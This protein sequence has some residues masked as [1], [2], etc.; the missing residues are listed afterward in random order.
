MNFLKKISPKIK[1]DRFL[2]NR[3]SKTFI[4]AELSGNHEGKIKNVFKAID[5]IKK[6]GA[7]AIK[8]QSYEPQTIT[9]NK[10]NKYFFINDKSIWKGKYL[11]DLYKQ[12][13]TP[14]S[15]HKKIFKYAKKKKLICF[16]SPFDKS[17]VDLLES[18][19]CPFYKIASPEITDLKLID[20]VSKKKKPIIISTGIADE[21]DINLA[22]NQCLKNNNKNII[23]LSCIS[24]YPTDDTEVNIK[25]INNLKKKV[26]HVGFSD[27][28]V[29]TLAPI[30]AVSMDAKIIEK[31][32]M[33][34]DKVVSHDKKFSIS[35]NNF[36]VM[37]E[38]IRRTEI[39]KGIS[40]P[41]K[42]KIINKKIKTI[43]RSLFYMCDLK[44]GSKIKH[45]DI[46]SFR[47]GVGLS[48]QNYF[49]LIGK[50]IKKNVK[51]HTPVKKKDF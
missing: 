43:S 28:T 48:P 33:I 46:E 13:F 11:Y 42:K 31:H 1:L 10:K 51:K 34:S 50:K 8:I 35:Y 49:L 21:N 41:N 20:Y 37:V 4:V 38:N 14:F 16:S 2:L 17:S 23:L 36:K 30:I 9:I 6:S 47:P 27:H 3:N 22:I 25:N 7:D 5:L 26:P 18:L 45:T 40:N 39:Q 24:S 44:K 12:S 15:W 19:K 29:D 32:F